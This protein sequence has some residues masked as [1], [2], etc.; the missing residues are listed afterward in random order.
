MEYITGVVI[1]D[2]ALQDQEDGTKVAVPVFPPG[3]Y[4]WAPPHDIDWRAVY[5]E[6]KW[7]LPITKMVFTVRV[8]KT[9]RPTWQQW[10]AQGK[11]FIMNFSWK[12]V[13]KNYPSL[14]ARLRF[15]P[16]HAHGRIRWFDKDSIPGD[17]VVCDILQ[18]FAGFQGVDF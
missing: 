18:R 13:A 4:G 16:C 11:I 12:E 17:A 2:I 5:D 15:W 6:G 1:A 10:Q 8:D 9:E 3:C 7:T 14:K